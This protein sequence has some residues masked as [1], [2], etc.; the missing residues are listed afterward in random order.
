M[1]VCVYHRSSSV[2]TH[3]MFGHI[4]LLICMSAC[5]FSVVQPNSVVVLLPL[6]IVSGMHAPATYRCI[7]KYIVVQTRIQSIDLPASHWSACTLSFDLSTGLLSL[8]RF[9]IIVRIAH[10]LFTI[11]SNLRGTERERERWNSILWHPNAWRPRL[12]ICDSHNT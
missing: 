6:A 11:H 3:N 10:F 4:C 12:T 2:M 1:C 8:K 5:V 9:S 7:H